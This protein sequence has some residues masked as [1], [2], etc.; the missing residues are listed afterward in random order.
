M[1]FYYDPLDDACKSVVGGIPEKHNLKIAVRSDA[2][3]VDL[4]FRADGQAEKSY[5]MQKTQGGFFVFESAFEKGLYWYSFSA[6]GVR[7]GQGEDLVAEENAD[8]DYQLTVF[9]SDY[10]APERVKGG[11]IY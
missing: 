8:G 9:K 7:F 6:D 5:P 11:V 2:S 4:V 10:A 1:Q 3:Y